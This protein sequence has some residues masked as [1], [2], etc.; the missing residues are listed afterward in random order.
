MGRSAYQYA[1]QGAD[2]QALYDA[3]PKLEA[4]LRRIPELVD[5]T[6]DLLLANPQVNVTLDRDR[7]AALGL[8]VDQV[9]NAMS[10]AYSSSQVATIFA[11]TNQYQILMR[12]A[13]EF[14]DRPDALS[15]LHVR[16]SNGKLIPLDTV[17]SFGQGVAQA[18]SIPTPRRGPHANSWFLPAPDQSALLRARHV[19]D[20]GP[21]VANDVYHQVRLVE[22]YPVAAL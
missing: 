14:Q 2:T 12:V 13:P 10:G 20:A 18:R 8:T 5:V 19:P 11:P 4:E 17:A 7:I 9:E 3:A 1:L 6:S 22:R 16:S 21:R 15:L